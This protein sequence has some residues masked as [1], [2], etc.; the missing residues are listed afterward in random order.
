MKKIKLLALISAA[1]TTVLLYGFLHA[2]GQTKEAV[3]VR[4]VTAAVD[5]PANTQIKAE[6][7]RATDLP[8]QA[9]LSDTLTDLTAVVGKVTRERVYQGEQLLRAKLLTAGDTTD[10]TLAYAVAPNMRAITIGVDATS[11]LSNMISQGN[12]VDIIGYFLKESASSAASGSTQKTSVTSMVLENIK[13]LAT[14]ASLSK[15][16]SG[17]GEST[18]PSAYQTITL[19]VTPEQAMKLSMAQSEGTLRA[20][21]RSP[22]DEKKK[23][24]PNITLDN[25]LKK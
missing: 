8:E 25:V 20:I 24:L 11:G 16:S 2:L 7:L 1:I 9:V 6:M 5:I 17:D 22:L 14:D 13:V 4:V 10:D 18:A 19:E 12:H 3:T 23:N 15:E 21:L